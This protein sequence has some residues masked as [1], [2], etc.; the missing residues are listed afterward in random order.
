[1]LSNIF[2]SA[3]C[4]N[5]HANPACFNTHTHIQYI[6][7]I[8]WRGKY[9]RA[10]DTLYL[11]LLVYVCDYISRLYRKHWPFQMSTICDLC[12][13]TRLQVKS[14]LCHSVYSKTGSRNLFLKAWLT[15]HC[16]KKESPWKNDE[17]H[18]EK[19]KGIISQGDLHSYVCVCVI[20]TLFIPV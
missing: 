10:F 5:S 13:S 19:N 1:M 14:S 8:R 16:F 18:G 7:S 4:V 11:V 17:G 9:R 3:S 6:H 15:F 2:R 20:I 12:D